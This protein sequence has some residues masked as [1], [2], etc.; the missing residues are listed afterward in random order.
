M[1]LFNDKVE[2]AK[3]GF[4]D[5]NLI[6]KYV[7]EEDIFEYVFGYLPKQYEYVTAPY[8]E[9][10]NPSCYLFTTTTGR[11][12]FSDFGN[13]VYVRG[14]KLTVLDCFDIVQQTFKLP[15]LYKTLLHIKKNLIDNKNLP[16]R[17]QSNKTLTKKVKTKAEIH[18]FPRPFLIEDK[19]FWEDKYGISKQNLIEDKVFPVKQFKL[20]NTKLG[21][22][23]VNTKTITYCYTDFES[24]NKKIYRPYEKKKF[25]TTCIANDVGG[26]RFLPERGNTLIITKSYKDYRVLKNQGLTVIWFQNEGMYPSLEILLPICNKFSEVILFFDNDET[27]IIAANK[28]AQI[29][30]SFIPN[31]ARI[32]HFHE[33]LLKL[34]IKDPADFIFKKGRQELIQFL[35]VNR[36]YD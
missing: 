18:F 35:I 15:N 11:L 28:I 34:G 1:D 30:N 10:S 33:S 13:T 36:I 2:V 21:D 22:Y 29:I 19:Y 17:E 31:K 24:E 16:I 7:S 12:C 27:G 9:D 14:N 3:R 4:I 20:L 8:R 5:K 6:L 32:V 26:I 25:Y 23:F